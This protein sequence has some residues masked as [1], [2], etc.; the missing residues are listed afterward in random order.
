M[1]EYQLHSTDDQREWTAFFKKGATSLKIDPHFLQYDNTFWLSHDRPYPNLYKYTSLDDVLTYFVDSPPEVI[2]NKEIDVALCFKNA[3]SDLCGGGYEAKRWF[4]MVDDFF[5]KAQTSAQTAKEEY[6]ITLNFVLDGDG[7]PWECKADKWL[8]WNSVWINTDEQSAACFDSDE[9]FCERFSILNDPDSADW[10]GM[11]GGTGYGKFGVKEDTPLQLW[12]PDS[13]SVITDF[14]DTYLSGRDAGVPSGSGL[15]FA[16]NIDSA[17]FDVFSSRSSL[18]GDE[19]RGYD[20]VVEDSASGTSPT[21]TST[22]TPGEFDLTYHTDTA[23]VAKTISLSSPGSFSGSLTLSD[24]ASSTHLLSPHVLPPAL[25]P[26]FSKV[27][28]FSV[29]NDLSFVSDGEFV[30]VSNISD[31]ANPTKPKAIGL[32]SYVSTSQLD[33][34][35]IVMSEGNHCYNSHKHNTRSY[36]LVCD[37]KVDPSKDMCEEILDYSL[38]TVSNWK[39]WLDQPN[40]AD[41]TITPCNEYILHGSW[42]GGSKPSPALFELEEEGLNNVGVMV[43]YESFK[44]TSESDCGTP[45]NTDGIVVS[46]FGLATTANAYSYEVSGNPNVSSKKGQNGDKKVFTY[47][48][49]VV[50]VGLVVGIFMWRRSRKRGGR[51]EEGEGGAPSFNSL[52][53]ESNL[54]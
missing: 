5:D 38:A 34:Q 50:L 1:A 7:K 9:A 46:S 16:I 4:S 21:L 54:I 52:R 3:P 29:E 8:P 17:M 10:A 19:R 14:I 18:A 36:P 2:H 48:L 39:S 31:P 30:Y 44:S 43:A 25:K 32:G 22:E 53:R 27:T 41:F 37:T 15:A 42:G 40:S 49:P 12:E 23:T 11:A 6:G 51:R 24:V 45:M 33:D 47:V 20:V 35:L 28:S 13:Q 26:L